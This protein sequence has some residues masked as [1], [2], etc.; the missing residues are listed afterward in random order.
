M[1]DSMFSDVNKIVVALSGGADSVVLTHILY[2]KF[3]KDK[4][5]CAHVNHGLRGDFA[6]RDEKFV[7]DFCEKLDVKIK[8]KRVDIKA[9][10]KEYKIG[11]E[12]C[13]RKVRYEFFN[14]LVEQND[15]I[16]TAHNA[17]DNAETVLLNLIRGS[18]AKGLCGIPIKRDNIIRPILHMSR[19]E[20][21]S[22]ARENGLDFVTDDT[23]F[24]NKY[25]RNKIRNDV[26]FSLNEINSKA[27][28]NINKTSKI[29]SENFDVLVEL[30][31]DYIKSNLH[32]AGLLVEALKVKSSAFNKNILSIYFLKLNVKYEEKH[33]TELES[34]IL[35]GGAVNLP[36]NIKAEINRNVLTVKKQQDDS[37]FKEFDIEFNKKYEFMDKILVCEKKTLDN[38][39][40]I[41]NLLFNNAVDYD[42][43]K[44]G[45]SATKRKKG[46]KF[47]VFGN[48]TPQRLKNLFAKHNIPTSLR[49][50]LLILR[51]G[52][53]IVFV[54][55][56][57]ISEKYL[58][59][60]NTK[61]YI[62][63]KMDEGN[64]EV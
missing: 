45:F 25:S 4:L 38:T 17:N 10:C 42:K 32:K 51:D 36:D 21:E 56:I 63:I 57:G 33:I 54:E 61:T 46:D 2:K 16:A 23:N 30:A 24:D 62:N 52:N 37:V 20:I 13:G 44:I 7:I 34:K 27:L 1:N 59:D 50:D 53:D 14:S 39:A 8:V 47:C 48:K 9:L 55:K 41:N 12:E 58:V 31:D 64:Y 11:E 49:D 15:V 40:K 22:Y 43:I 26:L 60:A 28:E 3:G 18:G 29:L 19:K 6:L 5:I 35:T